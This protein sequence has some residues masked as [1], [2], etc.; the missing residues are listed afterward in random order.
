MRLSVI[1]VSYNVEGFLT[2]CLVSGFGVYSKSG[3][4]WVPKEKE[5]AIAI[6][7]GHDFSY[8]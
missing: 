4:I 8:A 7:N 3:R 5:D 1:I 6:R 2:Q